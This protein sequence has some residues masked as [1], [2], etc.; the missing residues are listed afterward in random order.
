MVNK[1]V[2]LDHR[3]APVKRSMLREE[4]AAPG[5]TGV[6]SPLSAYPS[7][8]L[9]P[10][11]LATILREADRGDPIRY[12]ELAEI[13]EE[14]DPHYQGVLGTRKRSV[15][16]L[17][18]TVTEAGDTALDRQIAEELR[19]WINRDELKDELFDILDA[20]G[21]GYSHTEII[22]D[23]SA[24]QYWPKRLEWRDPRW[25]RFDRHDLKT[26]LM[27]DEHGAEVPY[28]AFK[29][30]FARM[31]AKSGLPLRSG[32]GRVASWGWLFKAFTQRDWAI[33]TQ[34]YGQPLRVG[35]YGQGAS[36]ADRDTL[37][38][39][40]ANIGGDCAAI[41]PES[42]MIEFIETGNLGSSTDHYERRSD[43]L[44]KQISKAV[45]GQTA[46]TD[47]V[48]GGLGSGDEHRQV[49]EDIEAAD[50]GKLVSIL[51][52]DLI[53][54]WVQ[55][56]YGPTALCPDISLE[57]PEE[58]DLKAF[59]D[60]VAPFIDRG[61]EVSEA[62]ILD[63]FN[64]PAPKK[65]DRILRPAG[66]SGLQTP[67][68]DGSTPGMG[69]GSQFEYRLNGGL[70]KFRGDVAEQAEGPPAGRSAPPAEMAEVLSEGM[71]KAMA[72][73]MAQIE[74]MMATAESLEELHE[75][76]LG[77]FP[78]LDASPLIEALAEGLATAELAGR[79]ALEAD[80]G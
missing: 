79:A 58:E 35:K 12:L 36:E 8:G 24:G 68:E 9:T 66:K 18:I 20:V 43:W 29:F 19:A 6:R 49:Q 63:K 30:I 21:K 40:V 47:A 22:W 61:M 10:D 27:L 64:L 41:I 14:R 13:V 11:R 15:T 72:P 7:D 74:E 78:T 54:P 16:Q 69:S 26:P 76:L 67:L 70:G 56:N 60:A 45:L 32:I 53:R 48:T 73:M 44:D 75:M 37:F 17:P 62:A 33:F 80:S 38:R 59:A 4:V 34:T 42:M 1:P 55:L 39:A 77:A 71:S 50:A 23:F 5:I 65:G 46:T 28:P 51:K 52:R 3:G 31:Q 57:R 25:F 2:L